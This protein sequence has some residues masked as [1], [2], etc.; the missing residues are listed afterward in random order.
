MTLCDQHE[1]AQFLSH[2]YLDLDLNPEQSQI[3]NFQKSTCRRIN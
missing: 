2:P 3:F 1:D